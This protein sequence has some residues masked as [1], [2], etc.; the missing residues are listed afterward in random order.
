MSMSETFSIVY[1]GNF[2][3]RPQTWGMPQPSGYGIG[4]CRFNNETG[5]LT[6]LKIVHD[7]ITAG[8]A[9]LDARR[10]VIYFGHEDM[11][12]P[13][14][15]YGGGGQVFAFSIDP[16]T[17]DL[18]EINHQPSYGALPVCLA[19]DPAGQYL[20]VPH[21]TGSFPITKVTKDANGRYTTVSE[22]DDA[23]VVLFPLAENGAI[24]DPCDIFIQTGTGGPLKQQTHPHLHS[25]SVSPSGKLFVVGDKGNDQI[26]MFRIDEVEH[27]LVLCGGKPFATLAGSSIRC[28]VF[29]PSKPFL[30][31]NFETR[32]VVASFRYDEDGGLEPVA[33]AN[34]LPEGVEDDLTMMQ[35]DIKVHPSGKNLYTLVRGITAVSVFSIDEV[36]GE[37]A[38][39]QTFELEG[40]NPRS[41]TIS[42]DGRFLLVA[43]I[44]SSEV[45]V[46]AIAPDGR[47]SAT[48]YKATQPHPANMTFLV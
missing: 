17:G 43:M 42:P 34:A 39:V 18:T 44:L 1:V 5:E 36:T 10:R 12:L 16:A 26:L 28:S 35:S 47:L 33:L 22:Y 41:C 23:S 15:P 4:I 2:R 14:R 32:A 45:L 31:A 24:G 9:L 27:K 13:D 37:L 3:M 40:K 8:N 46:L 6:P 38:R 7:H 11:T 21:H 48:G 25:V 19:Q 30:F 29:H 20:V